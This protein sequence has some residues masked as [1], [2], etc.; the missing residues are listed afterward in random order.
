MKLTLD[1]IISESKTIKS[2]I[3]YSSI[4]DSVTKVMRYKSN[5]LGQTE[6]ITYP[7]GER[8]EYSYNEAG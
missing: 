8:I 7:D 5:Y 3:K 2:M 6:E 1:E 4:G